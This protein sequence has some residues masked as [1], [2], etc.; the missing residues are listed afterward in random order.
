[1]KDPKRL[2]AVLLDKFISGELTERNRIDRKT[3]SR[4]SRRWRLLA[5]PLGGAST[6]AKGCD[7]CRGRIR[8]EWDRT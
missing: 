2:K 8:F 7:C 5:M 4:E 1:M 3:R 6:T